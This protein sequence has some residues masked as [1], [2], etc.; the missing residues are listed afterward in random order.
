MG[1]EL[2]GGEREMR[3]EKK[4][5]EERGAF[6]HVSQLRGIP[7]KIDICMWVSQEAVCENVGLF[8]HT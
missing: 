8:L 5:W 2:S 3:G 4:E 7:V 6:S 1:R